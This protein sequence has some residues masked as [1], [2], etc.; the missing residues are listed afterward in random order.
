MTMKLREGLEAGEGLV[1]TEEGQLQVPCRWGGGW[2]RREG[3]SWGSPCQTSHPLHGKEG[4]HAQKQTR[5]E[6]NRAGNFREGG[7]TGKGALCSKK[8]TEGEDRVNSL[9]HE[10][11]PTKLL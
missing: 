1:M 3:E 4:I 7:C 6:Q 9:G 11:S 5:F 2:I 10:D 8:D